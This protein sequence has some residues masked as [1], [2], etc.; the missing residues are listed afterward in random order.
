MESYSVEAILSAVDKNFTSTMA[1]ASSGLDGITNKF[2]SVTKGS[3]KVT[4]SI[5]SMAASMGLVKIASKAFDVMKASMDGAISR[6]DTMNN[7]PKMMKAMGFSAEESQKSIDKLSKGIQGLPTALDTVVANAQNIAIMTGDIDKATDTTLA[8][9]DAFLASGSSSADAERGLT[10]Y[11]QMLSKGKVDMQSWRTL[12]ETMGVALNDTAKA[13]GFAGASAQNDLYQALKDGNITFDQF[14]AKLIELDQGVG[15][16]AER[17]KTASGGIKTAMQNISTA[18]VRGMANS[19]EAIDKVL[20]SNGLPKMED[21]LMGIQNAVDGAFKQING[22]LD[23]FATA[24]S[25]SQ[26]MQLLQDTIKPIAPLLASIGASVALDGILPV[27]GKAQDGFNLMG[28]AAGK[29]PGKFDLIRTAAEKVPEQITA[30]GQKA[31]SVG[32]AMTSGFSKASGI[33]QKIIPNGVLNQFDALKG[34]AQMAAGGV[35]YAFENIA[36]KMKNIVPVGALNKFDALKGKAQMTASGVQYAFQATADKLQQPFQ[37][38]GSVVGTGLQKSASVGIQAMNGMVNGLMSVFQIAMS[39]IGPAAI[40]GLVVIGLGLVYKQ[41]GTQ[42]DQMIELV[43]TKGPEIITNLVQGIVSQLPALAESGAQML[44]TL[45]TAIAALLP[46]VMQA[47]MD[48]L[49]GIVQGFTENVDVIMQGALT[50]ITTLVNSIISLLPQLLICG[51]DIILSIVDGILANMSLILDSATSIMENIANTI[52]TNLPTILSK[53]MEILEKVAQGIV[54]ALPAL[55]TSALKMMTSIVKTISQNLP[56]IMQS[57]VKIIKTLVNGLVQNL[58]QILSAAVKLILEIVKG[59]VQ[60]LPKILE[61]GIKIVSEL[62]SGLIRSLPSIVTAAGQLAKGV[63]NTIKNT[64]WLSIG[65]NICKGI[66]NGIKNGVGAVVDAAKSLASSAMNSIKSKLGIH[67]PSRWGMWVGKM[68]NAGI[69]DGVNKSTSK[70]IN[71]AESMVN[72]IM[73][74]VGQLDNAYDFSSLVGGTVA[75][76]ATVSTR[77]TDLNNMGATITRNNKYIVEVPVNI[78]GRETAKVIA[79]FTDAEQQKNKQIKN[80]I[81]TGRRS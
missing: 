65:I 47:G 39:S 30:I 1:K 58:P 22:F 3:G 25:A 19:L 75:V 67:S 74:T 15:G 63:I 43:T 7:F 11:V 12:Q 45:M 20:T 41:F 29:I 79:P 6:F 32:G 9:N 62:V 40:I 37:K 16:F 14:N 27:V 35:G 36:D 4:S 13:F 8:L 51:L 80:L 55:I 71:A 76:G 46:T 23:K 33:M 28:A 2:S 17:A 50:L 26:K 56:Q 18:V 59:L 78:D 21:A 24:D 66:A 53:G 73:D 69:G 70:V 64:N 54:Q 48:I 57:A 68:L 72:N 31:Q 34:K 61:M 42:I 77:D 52:A 81:N 38:I 10:Q 44:N 5:T 60:N 49:K